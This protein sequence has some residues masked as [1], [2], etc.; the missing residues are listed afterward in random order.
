[1][2]KLTLALV[3]I[4]LAGTAS[5]AGWRSLRVDATSESAFERSLAEFKDKLSPARIDVFGAALKDIWAEGKKA[6][7]AE[8]REYTT[9]DYYRQVDG[10]SYEE[11][12]AF[13]DPTGKTARQRYTQARYSQAMAAAGNQRAPSLSRSSQ[14]SNQRPPGGWGTNPQSTAEGMQQCH[15][16]SPNGPQGN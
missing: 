16:M 8:Q 13:T 4:A 5:A 15:C 11:A 14:A 1:M 10:L 12:V 2:L 3:A 7:E 6:A 9:A